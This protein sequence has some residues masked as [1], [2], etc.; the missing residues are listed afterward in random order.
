MA[1]YIEREALSKALNKMILEDP[2]CPVFV[3]ATVQ[4]IVDLHPAA[5]VQR[6]RRGKWLMYSYKEA[7][8][9]CCGKVLKTSFDCDEEA[10][11]RWNELPYY[12]ED[13]GAMMY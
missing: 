13:C 11:D 6:I 9:N 1:E 12:C 10:A 8:C 7:I 3:A 2:N 5:D 4:Q